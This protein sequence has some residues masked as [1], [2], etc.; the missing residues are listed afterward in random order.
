MSSSVGT[1]GAPEDEATFRELAGETGL[2][3]DWAG[4]PNV[5]FHCLVTVLVHPFVGVTLH[6]MNTSNKLWEG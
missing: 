5:V 1:S 3:S 4:V 2:G 6:A